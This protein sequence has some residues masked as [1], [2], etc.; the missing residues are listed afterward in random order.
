MDFPFKRVARIQPTAFYRTE[1]QIYSRRAQKGKDVLKFQNFQKIFETVPPSLTLQ[2]Y[3][4]YF[5]TSV[6]RESKKN[7]SF[8]YSEI[9]GSAT[10]R[11]IMKSLD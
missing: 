7:V 4:R 11:N 8:E 5:L 2:P 10:E 1:L 3:S 9:V 6:N